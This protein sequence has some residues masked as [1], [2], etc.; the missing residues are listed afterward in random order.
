[1]TQE[2]ETALRYFVETPLP[3]F[4]G[5]LTMDESAKLKEWLAKR[6]EAAAIL[7]RLR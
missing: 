7:E 3:R 6:D 2:I 1:M 4:Y 5:G